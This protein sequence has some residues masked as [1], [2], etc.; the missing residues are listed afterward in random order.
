MSRGVG[1]K[2]GRAAPWF[3]STLCATAVVVLPTFWLGSAHANQMVRTCIDQTSGA[4]RYL[5]KIGPLGECRPNE[6]L[7]DWNRFGMTWDGAWSA[8][9]TY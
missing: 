8:S 9:T 5:R 3:A 6:K 4:P 2:S 7:F 1:S